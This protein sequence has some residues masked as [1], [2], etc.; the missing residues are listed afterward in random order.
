[1]VKKTLVLGASLNSQ[2]YSNKAVKLLISKG[3]DVVALGHKFGFIDKIEVIETK[4]IHNNIHTVT[5]YLN[6]KFQVQFYNYVLELK[7]KRVI[8]NPGTENLEF[9]KILKKN[10]IN[11]EESCTLV[12]LST[13]QF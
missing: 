11:Y 9:Y 12:L 1:M 5:I 2:K 3:L 7:P 8:F 13:D 10:S 6:K 4:K